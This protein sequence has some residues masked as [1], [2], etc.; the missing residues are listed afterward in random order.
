VKNALYGA[1]ILAALALAGCLSDTES[2]DDSDTAALDAAGSPDGSTGYDPCETQPCVHGTCAADG[3]AFVCTCEA[4]YHG[5]VCEETGSKVAIEVRSVAPDGIGDAI[6]DVELRD[7]PGWRER[8]TSSR[9]GD[10]DGGFRFTGD[11]TAG[12]VVEVR[13]NLVGVYTSA[14]P[15]GSVGVPGGPPA[16][17]LIETGHDIAIGP[18]VRE[19]P[20]D[21][22]ETAEV[23]FDVVLTREAA[24]GFFDI[25]MS[26]GD[27]F[28]SARFDC[29]QDD[30]GDGICQGDETIRL[31]FD[32]GGARAPTVV[33]GFAC[34]GDDKV[35]EAEALFDDLTL[36][37]TNT[38]GG[39][40]FAPDVSIT[41]IGNGN[42]CT[43]GPDGMSACPGITE[44]PG[45]DAD[46]FLYQVAT[47]TGFE[48]FPTGRKVYWNVAL[49]VRPEKIGACRIR[50]R[51]TG[52]NSASSAAASGVL[53]ADTV[54]PYVAWDVPLG[55]CASEHLW[56]DTVKATYTAATAPGTSFPY[57]VGEDGLPE[58][59]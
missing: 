56:T 59:F 36:D 43:A 22:E 10:G 9:F 1:A 7:A 21:L 52:A 23:W 35:V 44:A 28:C 32:E 16:A 41:P 17:S 15:E 5:V 39:G 27:L 12:D 26:V 11:C 6:W 20:C 30:D 3:F 51:A 37:C 33:L 18:L 4:G 55:E 24:Q 25:A 57:R 29:C 2:P 49:G 45:V 46:T 8:I 54:Y 19:V 58:A 13:A 31:L 50:A 14:V 42:Q 38:G 53:P 47:F 40:P 34:T 48:M